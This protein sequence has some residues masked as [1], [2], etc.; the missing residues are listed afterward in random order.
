M[1]R[2]SHSDCWLLAAVAAADTPVTVIKLH[3]GLLVDDS[4]LQG[5]LHFLQQMMSVD[6]GMFVTMEGGGQWSDTL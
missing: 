2:P 5:R 4:K 1:I 6:H 3:M